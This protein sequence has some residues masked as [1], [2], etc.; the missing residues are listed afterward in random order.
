YRKFTKYAFPGYLKSMSR[1]MERR[2]MLKSIGLKI[3]A[4]V[5][6]N[7]RHALEYLPLIKEFA[8]KDP[9]KLMDFYNLS[10]DEMAFILET[11]V[12][13]VKRKA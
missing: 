4:R 1:S 5:H 9:E 8:K 7:R 6:A 13:R 10:E 3:G 11:S 2:A 12:S